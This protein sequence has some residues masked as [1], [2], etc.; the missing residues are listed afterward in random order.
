MD[1]VKATCSPTSDFLFF[2][3]YR[4][5]VT[6]HVTPWLVSFCQVER[7]FQGWESNHQPLHLVLGASILSSCNLGSSRTTCS[8]PSMC[9][10]FKSRSMWQNTW[11]WD[12]HRVI[13]IWLM[14][15][16]CFMHSKVITWV[17]PSEDNVEHLLSNGELHSQCLDCF[18]CYSCWNT[19][20]SPTSRPKK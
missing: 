8:Q 3:E 15:V 10:I 12:P 11:K 16:E 9:L 1:I 4:S 18:H 6:G 17:T 5:H 14:E 19:R 20:Q 13:Q 2:W 7:R